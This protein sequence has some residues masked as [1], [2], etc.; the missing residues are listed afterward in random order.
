MKIPNERIIEHFAKYH[1]TVLSSIV[2]ANLNLY[3]LL[4]SEKGIV[5][6]G[7]NEFIPIV[8]DEQENLFYVV[9][10]DDCF[11][12]AKKIPD[13]FYYERC[14]TNE[15]IKDVLTSNNISRLA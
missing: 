10:D 2:N 4:N 7:M 13:I 15:Y 9:F 1:T 14:W 12:P 8:K 11:G 6:Y 3:G 5:R